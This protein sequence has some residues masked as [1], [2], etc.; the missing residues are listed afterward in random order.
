MAQNKKSEMLKALMRHKEN[1]RMFKEA[2]SSKIGSTSRA[3]AARVLSIMKKLQGGQDGQ[4]GPGTSYM[5]P[6]PQI[7]PLPE[8]P[9]TGITIFHKLPPMK[10]H[11]GTKKPDAQG[12]PGLSS[13]TSWNPSGTGGLSQF[14]TPSTPRAYGALANTIDAVNQGFSTAVQGAGVIAK[15]VP[16]YASFAGKN[17]LAA[18]SLPVRLGS[19]LFGNPNQ[20]DA[21][22][23]PKFT[24]SLS[25]ASINDLGNQIEDVNQKQTAINNQNNAA[26]TPASTTQP[27]SVSTLPAD[28]WQYATKKMASDPAFAKTMGT[29]DGV[30]S[31]YNTWKTPAKSTVSSIQ[32][33]GTGTANNPSGNKL[34][35][36]TVTQADGETF[37]LAHWAVNDDGSTNMTHLTNVQNSLND[38]GKL[39][40]AADITNWIQKTDPGSPITAEMVMKASQTYGVPWEIILATANAET[41]LGTDG[42]TGATTF[43]YGNV[44]NTN[45][46]MKNG[47]PNVLSSPQE[48]VDAIAKTLTNGYYARNGQPSSPLT[49]QAGGNNTGVQNAVANSTGPSMYAW[50]QMS[51]PNNPI[52]GGLSVGAAFSKNYSTLWDKYDLGNLSAALDNEKNTQVNLPADTASYIRGRDVAVNDSTAKIKDLQAKLTA[53]SDPTTQ[54][55]LKQQLDSLYVMRGAQT[56]SYIG[57]IN[58]AIDQENAKVTN[59]TNEYNT[60]MAAFQNDVAQNNSA[61][62][63]TYTQYSA[64]L[65]DLYNSVADAPTR[66][67][68]LQKLNA[69]VLK[70]NYDAAQASIPATSTLSDDVAK[71][72]KDGVIQDSKGFLIPG[73]DLVDTIHN[74][75]GDSTTPGSQPD[76]SASSIIQYYLQSV[77]KSLAA[78][79][80]AKTDDGALLDS[81][82]K[83]KIG[84]DAINQLAQVYLE[85]MSVKD[86]NG[87]PAPRADVAQ[88]A[89]NA[90]ED[91]VSRL[92]SAIGASNSTNDTAA[93]QIAKAIGVLKNGVGGFV[94]M[95][96]HAPTQQE[97]VD[98]FVKTVT[99]LAGG[100]STAD[101][102]RAIWFQYAAY[103]DAEKPKFVNSYLTEQQSTTNRGQL[104]TTDSLMQEIGKDY[105]N[106]MATNAF[107]LAN[108]QI[109]SSL[110]G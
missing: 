104:R 20:S 95:G 108:T 41:H 33:M 101:L 8:Q 22:T 3:K 73:T 52:T 63:A 5:Q 4:G 91:I 54:V 110:S 56:Q 71:L 26:K 85:A 24:G 44:G 49:A 109:P 55:A 35:G 81:S 19:Y 50:N 17:I 30:L 40:S 16:G 87:Q 103:D 79:S 39:N 7:P 100:V 69:E 38:M 23:F 21:S 2:S 93:Q 76:V 105:A 70:A 92:G 53:T 6:L 96:K 89:T 43:N 97:F 57:Y 34:L 60:K 102:A 82:H 15:D 12:G 75:I 78:D 98:N 13:L 9:A 32:D 48:G 66:A 99:A 37:N 61:T 62:Q 27:S 29:E 107:N 58:T 80:T 67:A 59:L 72:Q 77:N 14:L 45:T 106:Y 86:A 1:V 64:A 25:T 83:L 68:N 88:L 90:K 28:F 10:I 94:G 36:A 51:D 42:S 84:K 65:A 47:Q 74:L 31:A 11:Y 46:A 18:G